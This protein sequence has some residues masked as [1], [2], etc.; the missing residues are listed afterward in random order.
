MIN[1]TLVA[2]IIT[3]VLFNI[4]PIQAEKDAAVQVEMVAKTLNKKGS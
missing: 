3:I 2:I 1:Q 4:A